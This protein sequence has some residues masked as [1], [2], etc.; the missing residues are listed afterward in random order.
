MNNGVRTVVISI[1]T[2]VWAINF[3]APIFVTD[4]TPSPELNVAF[5]AIIGVL[6]ASYKLESKDKKPEPEPEKPK[7]DATGDASEEAK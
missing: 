4:Y 7:P 3:T 6:T 2:A 1:V 5:M